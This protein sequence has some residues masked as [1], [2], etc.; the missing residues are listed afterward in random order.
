MVEGAAFRGEGGIQGEAASQQ[1][2]VEGAHQEGGQVGDQEGGQVEG[3]VEGAC[4]V[5]VDGSYSGT[6][7]T[8]VV[9]IW[10]AMLACKSY[11]HIHL[12]AHAA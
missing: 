3:E 7:V 2:E 1:L 10:G 9:G 11:Q 4:R 8:V 12:G 6:L 5:A